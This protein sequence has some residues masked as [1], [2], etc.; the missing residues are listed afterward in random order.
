MSV[1][2]EP[3]LEDRRAGERRG[4][5]RRNLSVQAQECRRCCALAGAVFIGVQSGFAH[6]PDVCLF[7]SP[8][9]RPICVPVHEVTPLRIL[10][11]IRRITTNRLADEARPNSR[12]G[13][14]TA[15]QGE[16]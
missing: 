6:F 7:R 10:S 5:D 3:P 15:M 13:L 1:V 11:E 4:A 8:S 12:M 14:L 2:W 16:I 9:G